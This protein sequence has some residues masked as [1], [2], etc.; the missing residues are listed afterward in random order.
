MAQDTNKKQGEIRFDGRVAIVTGAGGGLGRAYAL[1]LG[2]RGAKVVVND[3]GGSRDGT[4]ADATPAQKVVDE[5]K[6]AGGEA[7][8]NYDNVA[9]PEGG[10]A[11]VK[12]AL[13][14]FG[15]LDILINNA[16]I[17]RDKSFL[18]MEPENWKAVMDV[19]LFGAYNVTKPAFAAMKQNSY[20]RIIMTTSAAGLFGNFGQTNYSSAKMGLV[21]LMNTLKL[22]GGKSNIKVNTIAPLAAS[23]LTEDV[24]PP[25]LFAKSKPEFVVPIVVYLCSEQCDVTGRI[26]N[27]G[28][29]YYNRSAVVTGPGLA[30]GAGGKIPTPDDIRDKIDAIDK[31]TGA[32]EYN[33]LN[34]CI[35]DL[36][37][38]LSAPPAA[39]K[40][41]A[42]AGG[43][44]PK[45]AFAQLEKTFQPDAAAGLDIVFQY[46][47]TGSTG[48]AWN[49]VIKDKTC[50]VSE[51]VHPSPTTTLIME[52]K[53]FMAMMNKTLSAMKAYTSGKLKIEGDLM[54]SQ[55]LEKLFKN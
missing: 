9:T 34:D 4:G 53:D 35:M 11:I 45:D 31:L 21:G 47:I 1:E 26:Y 29:G 14:A 25:E 22:E 36:I 32:K 49:A 17:L 44:T 40:G 3:L 23:R 27:A 15:K 46:K 52:D 38:A 51:G 20:G 13:D 41:S 33:Q 7:V 55:L 16:G 39:D 8:P 2:R 5:I 18:K 48:G 6:A 24:M 10:A 42:A 28:M 19:H 30:L 50:K 43:A 12:T 37:M 54:K